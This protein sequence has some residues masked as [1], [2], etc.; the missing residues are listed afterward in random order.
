MIY[1]DASA[2]LAGLLTEGRRPQESLWDAALVSSRQLIYEVWTRL[3]A[4]SASGPPSAAAT[5]LLARV[6]LVEMSSVALARALEPFPVELRTQDALHVS[7]MVWLREEASEIRLASYDRRM[8]A[9]A[10]ALG[11][12]LYPL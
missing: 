5:Q 4:R 10:E 3:N 9:C 7:T 12:E 6:N 2:V 8:R 11:F 1:L